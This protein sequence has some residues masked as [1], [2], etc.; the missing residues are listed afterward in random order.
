MDKALV[1]QIR[2]LG[3]KLGEYVHQ[4]A[5]KGFYTNFF[6]ERRYDYFRDLLMQVNRKQLKSLKPPIITLDEFYYVFE[7]DIDD[8]PRY[9]RWK[10]ARDLVL[11]RMT[12]YLYENGQIESLVEA[13][14]EQ[15][16]IVQE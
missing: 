11:I 10:L 1:E 3:D 14:P 7:A 13:L 16:D 5:D 8:I 2:N 6:S 9:D 15:D 12:E 4:T